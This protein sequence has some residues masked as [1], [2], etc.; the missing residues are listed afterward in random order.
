[1]APSVK[2]KY[3]LLIY[4]IGFLSY[5]L[6]SIIYVKE[7]V[8]MPDTAFQLF[9]ILKTNGFAIQIQRFGAALVQIFPL[10][11]L[12]LNLSLSTIV[13]L[14]S[15]AYPL[16]YVLIF[17]FIV[18]VFRDQK[19]A[20]SF[21]LFHFLITTHSFYWFQCELILGVSLV[22]FYF[23]FITFSKTHELPRFQFYVF[24]ILLLLTLVFIHPLV[25]IP[26]S[27][28]FFYG[29]LTQDLN[30][31]KQEFVSILILIILYVLKSL[32]FSN[33]YDSAALE[34]VKNV[35]KLFPQYLYG[36]SARNFIHYLITN[37]YFLFLF[38]PISIRL[39]IKRRLV[40]L[41]LLIFY[42][43]GTIILINACYIN[44]ADQFYLEGQYSI[45]TVFVSTILAREFEF[46]KHKFFP[47]FLFLILVMFIYRIV[48]NS[49][50]YR[51]RI[52]QYRSL[53][54]TIRPKAMIKSSDAIKSTLKMTWGSSYEIWLLSTL[55]R[56]RS[57][58]LIILDN[59]N[60]FDWTLNRND[61]F[62]T[63]WEV[64]DYKDLNSKYFIFGDSTLYTKYQ[65]V[66]SN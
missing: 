28:Y 38:F 27:F 9:S 33:Y 51:Y 48:D 3:P 10:I 39:Y 34:N 55:E 30:N 40:P 45:T 44:G 58:S 22:L 63:N 13:Y 15:I 25:L 24:N 18:F 53:L 12:K 46:L 7:R 66:K 62:L 19:I 23:S 50:V 32:F 59:P 41:G 29:F 54:S 17:G 52:D 65:F 31:Q 36:V 42:F 60:Q 35:F 49:S 14:Y 11:G 43:I 57:S 8:I 37:Y 6:L 64:F 20:F 16:V 2:S 1:M 4:F 26:L 61:I 21:F 47:F 5:L 56:G